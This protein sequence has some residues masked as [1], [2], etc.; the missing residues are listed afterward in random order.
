MNASTWILNLL[1]SFLGVIGA[2]L[3]VLLS[4]KLLNYNRKRRIRKALRSEVETSKEQIDQLINICKKYSITGIVPA[5]QNQFL[6]TIVFESM[7]DKIGVLTQAEIDKT[8]K[9]Y[10]LI[11]HTKTMVNQFVQNHKKMTQKQQAK[12]GNMIKHNLKTI[13]SMHQELKEMLN[14]N[15]GNRWFNF[16]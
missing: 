11:D 8:I 14:K 5:Q 13:S 16:I 2:L 1:G 12:T 10:R 15:L 7:T 3:A 6:S 9:L 4:N